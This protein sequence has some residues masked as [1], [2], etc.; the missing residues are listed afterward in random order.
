MNTRR[1][2]LFSLLAVVLAVITGQAAAQSAKRIQLAQLEQ[3]FTNMRAQT[4]WNVDGPLLWGYF[5]FDPSAEKLQRVAT[6]L[7][8]MGYHVVSI[9][10]PSGKKVFRLH[11]EKV[12]THS[13]ASLGERN[14]Q[15]Y[16]LAERYS[17]ASYDGMDVGPAPG[18]SK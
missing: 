7:E 6:E 3:M 1:I 4:K 5:F 13:P 16:A 10:Q 17:L 14:Q 2:A 11:V 8:T 9:E 18:A 12:E 15:F